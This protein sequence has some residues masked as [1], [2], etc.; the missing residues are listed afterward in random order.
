MQRNNFNDMAIFVEVARTNGFRAAADKLKLG[1]GSVSE[2]VQRF[3]DRIGVRLIDRTTRKIAL[4]SAGERL[5][6]RSLPAIKDLESAILELSDDLDAVSGTLRLSAPYASGT[7]FLNDLLSQYSTKYPSVNIEII[8]DDEKVDLVSAKVD[9][10]IRAQTLLE[11][12]THAISIGPSLDLSVVAS[13]SYI[14]DK[15]TPKTPHDI[16][17]HDGI[18][19]AFGNTARLA[20]WTFVGV[21]GE[22][23]AMPK[24]RLMV[25]DMTSML[26]FAEAGL[27]LAYLYTKTAE[28]SIVQGKLVEVLV[29]QVPSLPRYSINYL[30]K[31]NMPARLRAFIELAKEMND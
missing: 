20:P 13:P 6:Q 4:T 8:Y 2:A 9:A 14:K 15:G 5:Y 3:E 17:Q 26:H 21:E 23:T 1:A 12:D 31:R 16:L 29:G 11:K 27:G 7:F 28:P 10:T 25:N 18:C 19:F 24:P 22:Y 30:S